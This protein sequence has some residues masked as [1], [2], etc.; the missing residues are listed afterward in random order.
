[1]KSIGRF[2]VVGGISTLVDFLIYMIISVKLPV[3]ISKAISMCI[4]CVVSFFLNR[5]WTFE[6]S[7]T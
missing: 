4:S 7:T 2:I 5:K 3:S 1:M 6:V